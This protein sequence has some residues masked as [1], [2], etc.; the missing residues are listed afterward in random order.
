VLA[1]QIKAENLLAHRRN[2]ASFPSQE[3]PVSDDSELKTLVTLL[4]NGIAKNSPEKPLAVTTLVYQPSK[5][6]KNQTVS[7]KT[8]DEILQQPK[9]QLSEIDL[10]LQ[11]YLQKVQAQEG[12]GKGT[13]Q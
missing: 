13:Q 3:I 4:E 2:A 10:L 8:V 9:P 5:G 7:L 1:Y 6:E 12:Q 11:T